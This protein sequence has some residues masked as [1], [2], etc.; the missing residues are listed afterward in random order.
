MIHA[1]G[2]STASYE[3]YPLIW[4]GQRGC[5][6]KEL[7]VPERWVGETGAG[8]GD[9]QGQKSVRWDQTRESGGG[10]GRYS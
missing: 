2:K 1:P 4:E 3:T 9:G 10:G 7:L 5:S 8:G 6:E